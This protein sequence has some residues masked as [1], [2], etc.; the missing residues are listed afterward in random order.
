M[1]LEEDAIGADG[2]S[3]PGDVGDEFRLSSRAQ[4]LRRRGCWTLCEAS[5]T[6]GYPQLFM[7]GME[8]TSKTRLL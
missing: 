3:G 1:D 7:I 2:H 6:T 4:S 5:M 8:R